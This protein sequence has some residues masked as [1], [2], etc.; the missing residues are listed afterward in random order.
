MREQKVDGNGG[1]VLAPD[2]VL[3]LVPQ[4]HPFRFIDEITDISEDRI[5][6]RYTFRTD[7]SF[8][9]GHFPGMPLTP[10]VILLETMAQ[11]GV[12]ALGIYLKALE[13]GLEELPRWRSIFTD[14]EVEF[15]D[16]VL[17]GEQVI[18]RGE[19]IFWRRNKLRSK[20]EMTKADGSVV[21]ACTLSGLGIRIG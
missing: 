17:P 3:A 13:V 21:A 9:E 8:Y 2:E 12:V 14:A 6:G 1:R 5:E 4:Q 19:K 7:E 11:T 15:L 16:G 10:G 20:V 18:C